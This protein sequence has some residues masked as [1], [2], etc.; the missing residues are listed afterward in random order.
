MD[1]GGEDYR[2]LIALRSWRVKQRKGTRLLDHIKGMSCFIGAFAL[3]LVESASRDT[4]LA[5]GLLYT[6]GELELC[7]MKLVRRIPVPS[8]SESMFGNGQQAQ[9]RLTG[10]DSRLSLPRSQRSTNL[11]PSSPAELRPM[12][13]LCRTGLIWTDPS[14]Y[15]RG[16]RS[17]A[18]AEMYLT[19][20]TRSPEQMKHQPGAYWAWHKQIWS[21]S[22]ASSR[23]A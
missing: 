17:K 21:A 2:G 15:G 19:S 6:I 3:L 11:G 8:L 12:E 5:A 16:G 7:S 4:H 18:L 10:I 22:R 1:W 20:P 9:C 23:G 14:P 13:I